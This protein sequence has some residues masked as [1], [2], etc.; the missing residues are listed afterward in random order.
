[1]P[2]LRDPTAL[3][4][5]VVADGEVVGDIVTFFNEDRREVGYWI[6]REHSGR[7]IA[8][9]ALRLLLEVETRRPLYAGVVPHNAGSVRVLEK[10]GFVSEGFDGTDLSFR[11]DS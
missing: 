3:A 11:L 9:R 6:A 1:M 5:T 2:I 8:T 10:C 7:E 4:R